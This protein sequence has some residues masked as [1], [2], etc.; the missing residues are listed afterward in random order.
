M[1]NYSKLFVLSAALVL[2][3]GS[4]GYFVARHFD[5]PAAPAGESMNSATTYQSGPFRVA[6]GINPQAPQVGKNQLTV[7]VT[8][9]DG[10]PVSGARIKAYGEMP[11][12]GAMPSMRAPADLKDVEPGR[13]SGPLS[14][15]MRGEWP[16]SIHIQKE[17]VGETRLGFDM[18]T[19]REGLSVTSGG[20]AVAGSMSRSD[21]RR[22]DKMASQ[23]LEKND[24]G[25]YTVGKYQVKVE[26]L[27]SGA[28]SNDGVTNKREAMAMS[29]GEAMSAV[30][31]EPMEA[32]SKGA[33]MKSGPNRLQVTVRDQDDEPVEGATVRVAAQL[34]KGALMQ[35]K[36]NSEVVQLEARGDGVYA[37]V[38]E[39]PAD[40]DYVL[41]VDVSTAAQGHGDLVLAFSTGEYGLRAAT[42]TPEGIAYYTCSMHPSVREAG[43]G[44]CPICS[45]DL[46]SVTHEEVSSGAIT[47]DAQRRQLIGV[48]TAA[49]THRDLSKIIRAVGKV[50]YDE[51]RISTVSLKFDAWIGDLKADFVGTQVRRGQMWFS[52]YSPELLSAQQEYLETRQRLSSRRPDDSLVQAARRRLMLWDISAAQVAA[53]ERGGEALEY[54]PIFAP[55]SGTVVEKMVVEGSHMKTGDTL[56]RI[57]DL[58]KV[59]IDA[60]VYEADLPSIKLG[61]PAR[62]T[63]P[64]LPGVQIESKVDYIYP[65]LEGKT[66]TARIRLEIGNPDGELKPDMYADV[67]LQADL[68]HRLVI[69]EEAVLVAGDTRVVFKDLGEDGKLMPVRVKTGARVDGFIVIEEGLQLGDKVV[70]SGNFLIAAE[71]KL[72][73]GVQQ[74]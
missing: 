57:A 48:K 32:M 63:L 72:K 37:G 61:M 5:R 69:P 1:K 51:R 74:W 44:S 2:A 35:G 73:T 13:Y 9:M 36:R 30:M 29:S 38:L 3:F 52:V 22:G 34:E 12:M 8:D 23:T 41:A 65:Y 55:H 54:L 27:G 67:K 64:Y 4:A 17:G 58:S 15:E 18:A 25:F 71:A 16:L 20:T 70:T 10:D 19:G 28:T 56:L 49:A 42:A 6:V 21:G 11:A 45:M 47:V 24:S 59:W 26:V 66:R 46:T 62:V 39:L 14:L 31:Q 7:T 53:L 60:E 50:S 33:A 68:G 40:G 43:P